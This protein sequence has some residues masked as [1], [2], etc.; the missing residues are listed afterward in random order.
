MET[1]SAIG[2]GYGPIEVLIDFK[3]EKGDMGKEKR[4]LEDFPIVKYAPGEKI[5]N[6]QRQHSITFILPFIYQAISAIFVLLLVFFFSF[7]VK[8]INLNFSSIVVTSYVVLVVV[9]TFSLFATFNFLSW[10]FRFYIIT[11]KAIIHRHCFRIGG[12]YSETVYADKMHVQ[13][14]DRVA[15][16]VVYDYL[17]IQDVYV[18]FHK[19]EREEP[20]VFRTPANAQKIDDLIQGLIIESRNGQR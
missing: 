11:N 8:N 9:C 7:Y 4:R 1:E 6:A 15:I 10:F 14:V 3:E 19:L 16:N 5:L 13:D 12:E 18:Y 2:K 20:F 17:K